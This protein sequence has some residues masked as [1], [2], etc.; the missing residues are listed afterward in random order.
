[1]SKHVPG[2]I[3]SFLFFFTA[4][5]KTIVTNEEN[6]SPVTVSSQQIPQSCE[7]REDAARTA[8]ALRTAAASRTTA[9][10]QTPV[11]LLLDFNG[12]QVQNSLWNPNATISCPAVPG[13]LLSKSMKD[14]IFQSVAED[15]SGFFVKVTQSEQEYQAAP[16]ARRMRCVLTY[17]MA[18]QFGNYGGI[19]FINSMIWGDNTPCFVFCDVLQYNQKYISG[20]VSHE[21]GHTFG[22]QHQSRYSAACDLEEEYHTGFGSDALGWA[23]VM[24]ISYYQSIIT[25]HNGPSVIGCDQMQND[26]DIIRTIAGVKADDYGA[27]FNSNTIQLPSSG[28]KTGVLENAGDNDAFL[29]KETNSKRIKVTPNGNSDIALEVYNTNGQLVTVYDDASGPTVNAV[30][31]GK[32]YIKVR[33]SANQPYVP[34]GD[35]FGGYVINVSNP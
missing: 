2:I 5:K 18:D 29:K 22:L 20:A 27:S 24:G 10:L 25:W 32:K 9:A 23:P 1:M 34:G 33:V 21:L 11:V 12:Q 15:Y 3:I 35:G 6:T 17:N 4:C 26:M 16:P 30:I 7:V 19:A 31:S 28:T 14:Y 8:E 13:S